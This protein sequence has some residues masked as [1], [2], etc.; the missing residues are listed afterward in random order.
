LNAGLLVLAYLL[1]SIPFAVLVSRAM[2][3]PDPRGFGSGN[4][5]ATNVLRSGSRVGALLTL[6]GDA[7]KGA[8]AVGVALLLADPAEGGGATRLAIASWCGALAFLGH[9]APVFLRFRG[10]KGVATFLGTLL[11]IAPLL[12]LAACLT[13]LVVALAFRYS[14]LA[15]IVSAIVATALSVYF[16]DAPAR[17]AAITFMAAILVYRHRRNIAQLIAGTEGR[18]GQK[19]KGA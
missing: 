4:P 17:L 1:G 11:A 14:S 9:V 12:G 6:L 10:G 3:L 13:W 19:S 15:S 16:A 8:L 7:G 2:G 5:G 18:I